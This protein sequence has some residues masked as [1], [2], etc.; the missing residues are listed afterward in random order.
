M[1]PERWRQINDLFMAAL[2]QPAGERQAFL[3]RA[4]DGD[5]ELRRMVADM[6]AVDQKSELPLDHSPINEG[7]DK[8]ID[9][10][11]TLPGPGISDTFTAKQI[12]AYQLIRELGRGGMGVVCLAQD[13]RLERQVALKL[14]PARLT[15][16]SDRVRRFQ[17]EARAVSALNHPNIITIYDFGEEAGHFYIASE[18]VEGNTLRAL[19]RDP[20][21]TLT[22]TLDILI[23]VAS[24]LDAAHTAGIVHRDI[25]PEN[26]MLRPD[27]YVKVLDFGLAKLIEP[28]TDPERNDDT[29]PA[30]SGSAMGFKTRAGDILGTVNYMSPEQA[31]GHKVDARSDLFSLGVVFYELVTGRRPFDGPTYSHTLVA[32]LDQE[33]PPLEKYVENA[34]PP[35]QALISRLLDKD[36][37]QR[38]QTAGLLLTELRALRD[39]L[40]AHARIRL[41]S[42]E[43]DAIA[44][45]P[46]TASRLASQRTAFRFAATVAIVFIVMSALLAWRQYV[47]APALTSRDTILLADFANTTG[48]TVFDGTLQQ[49]LTVQLT[50]SPYL[51]ILPEDRARETLR[52]MGRTREQA[53]EEKITLETG[54]EICQRRGIKALLSGTIASLGNNYVITLQTVSSQTGE[55]IAQQQT[56]AGSREQVLGALGQAAT[57]LREKLGE[58]LPSIRQFNAPIE[59]ATTPSLEALKDYST[60]AELQRRGQQEKAVPFFRLAAEHDHDFALAYLRLGVSLRDLRN[61]AQGNQQLERAWRL[62]Q[63]VSERERLNISAT[64]HRYITGD[65]AQRL[66]TTLLWAQTY[67]QDPGAH[68]IHG[69]S[70]VVTGQYEQAVETYRQALA[71]DP[72]YALSRANLAIS[73][74]GLNRYDEARAAIAEG[75]AR[76]SDISVFHNRL[77]LFAFL[78]GDSGEM[79]RQSEWFKGRSDEYL[80]REWQGRAAACRGQ[81]GKA[82]EFLTQAGD[83]AAARGLYAEHARILSIMAH[84]NAVHGLTAPARQQAHRAL[85]LIAEKHIT[86]QELSPTPIGQ[87]D[88]QPA[89]WT[90]ALT[91]ETDVART[92]VDELRRRMPVDTLYNTLWLPLIRGAIE[93]QDKDGAT[94]SLQALEPARQYEPALGLRLAWMRGQAYLRAGDTAAAAAE[95]ERILAHRGWDVLSPLW[96]LG[97]L[98]LARA[99]AMAGDTTKSRR[100]YEA[101]FALWSAADPDMPVLI[102]A[103][104]E[105]E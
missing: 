90:L 99:T 76:G 81:I 28:E 5:A 30:I 103:R 2:D 42:G 16:A 64:Y 26:I 82:M 53:Q 38:I 80:M 78:N 43:H 83:I 35:L 47:R 13:T 60:G 36:R 29:A 6:L 57:A 45:L 49:G 7:F 102:E 97:H 72:D 44:S 11:L 31:R 56:E 55:I 25:K 8:A 75:Q 27:G 14:L 68:H 22:R 23:Q 46:T 37:E 66:E 19:I 50:Q 1:S 96:P 95:F 39:E 17:R 70:L 65:L 104:R 10:A 84:I 15:G 9:G 88:A 21:L 92:Q 58:S 98:G 79:T 24:A 89:A 69:N 52:L 85:A 62:R 40:T 100:Q 86:P 33:P 73:L 74:I 105:Y 12:G 67:P 93:L 91:G 61:L 59:Q 77:F 51:N 94:R 20:E 71:L 63:R 3:A 101:L 32:I 48:D 54:R 34:P 87:V 41:N 4:C 18:Y